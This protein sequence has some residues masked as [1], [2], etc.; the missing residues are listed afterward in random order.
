MRRQFVLLFV[1]GNIANDLSVFVLD[2]ASAAAVD[3]VASAFRL[4]V[5]DLTLVECAVVEAD[6]VVCALDEGAF[7]EGAHELLALNLHDTVAL[8][9][10]VGPLAVV[11]QL[12]LVF[13]AAMPHALLELPDVDVLAGD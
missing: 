9:S 6:G 10:V 8:G 2:E 7:S 1:L 12:S 3:E 13:A 4:E 5:L 11:V